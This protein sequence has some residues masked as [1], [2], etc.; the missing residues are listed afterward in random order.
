VIEGKH[1][2][3][4]KQHLRDAAP[5]RKE[6][7]RSEKAAYNATHAHMGSQGA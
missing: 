6:K 7:K 1:A 2:E 4:K 5:K 3:I